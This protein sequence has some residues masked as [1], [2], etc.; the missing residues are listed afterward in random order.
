MHSEGVSVMH[1]LVSV[2]KGYAPL[3]ALLSV[4]LPLTLRGTA[5]HGT[6]LTSW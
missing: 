1:Y 4:C 6:L 5:Y 2:S 3:D